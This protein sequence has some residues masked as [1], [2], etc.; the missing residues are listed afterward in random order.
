MRPH[1]ESISVPKHRSRLFTLR[2]WR[3]GGPHIRGGRTRGCFIAKRRPRGR[4]TRTRGS[5]HLLT[6]LSPLVTRAFH[7]EL[8]DQSLPAP[9]KLNRGCTDARNIFTRVE[10]ACCFTACDKVQCPFLSFFPSLCFF[11]SLFFYLDSA[12][13]AVRSIIK[14]N[15]RTRRW[16][17]F[18]CESRVEGSHERVER[19]DPR[20]SMRVF[21]LDIN[22]PR[23]A[24]GKPLALRRRKPVQ[25]IFA[26]PAGH[27]PTRNR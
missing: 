5:V 23:A 19:R 18:S 14:R 7:R 24:G 27:P 22:R 6:G 4:R 16:H 8:T 20:R 17:D 25:L 3:R 11:F 2:W 21:G 1:R 26:N 15:F 9:R 13:N 10:S 12:N